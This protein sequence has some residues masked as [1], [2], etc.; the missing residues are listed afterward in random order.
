MDRLLKATSTAASVPDSAGCLAAY[1]PNSYP[2]PCRFWLL[3]VRFWCILA[4]T[5]TR[6]QILPGLLPLQR[7]H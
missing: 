2:P 7:R 6:Q 1:F 5:S 3:S 4:Q